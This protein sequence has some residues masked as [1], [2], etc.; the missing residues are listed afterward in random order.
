MAFF[1]HGK[2]AR[3]DTSLQSISITVS[4]SLADKTSHMIAGTWHARCI[5]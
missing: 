5:A 3:F 1:A 2:L 4:K